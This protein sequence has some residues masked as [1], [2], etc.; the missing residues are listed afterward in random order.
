MRKD[1][2]SLEQNKRMKPDRPWDDNKAFYNVVDVE[3]KVGE[4][5]LMI[6]IN[7]QYF[8]LDRNGVKDFIKVAVDYLV[9]YL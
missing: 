9:D 6:E 4:K 5:V 7:K 8:R 3:G 2:H 1:I